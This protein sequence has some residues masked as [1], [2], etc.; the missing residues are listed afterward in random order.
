MIVQSAL[1]V[2]TII[3]PIYIQDVLGYSAT[4]S[5][6]LMMPG[7]IVMG[8]MEPDQWPII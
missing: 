8:I 7:A 2:G 5:G 1:L 4:A 6:L 3:V